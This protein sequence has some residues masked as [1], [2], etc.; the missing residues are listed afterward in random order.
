M[1]QTFSKWQQFW[2]LIVNDITHPAFAPMSDEF[3]WR[4][5]AE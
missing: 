5:L 4:L 3:Y 2:F 1:T